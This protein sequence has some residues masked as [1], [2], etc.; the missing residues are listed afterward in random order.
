MV[1]L[2][3][4]VDGEALLSASAVTVKGIGTNTPQLKVGEEI[5]GGKAEPIVGTTMSFTTPKP[6]SSGREPLELACFSNTRVTFSQPP[7]RRKKRSPPP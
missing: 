2:P 5:Y 7:A 1:D 4:S 3:S 6:G